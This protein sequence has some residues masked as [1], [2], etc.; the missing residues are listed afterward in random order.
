MVNTSA[1]GGVLQPD[2]APAPL[3]GKAFQVFLQN[4]I[5][6]LC[7]LPGNMVRPRWQPEPDNIPK[8]GDAWVAFGVVPDRSA[9]TFP[10]VEEL[11]DGL[12]TRLQR[13]E[14]LPILCSFYD[15]GS[16]GLA[17]G[18][19][20]LLRDNLAI[21]QNW[22]PLLA[23]GF[24]LAHVGSMQP[25]PVLKSERWLY[26][27]DLSFVLRRQIDRNYN[28]RSLVSAHG[29][30]HTDAGIPPLEFPISVRPPS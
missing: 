25:S 7:D 12:T 20:S 2:A 9:D 24:M 22:E 11:N 6:P 10:Y 4:W 13:Q 1:S 30:I 16:T 29:T 3:E 17:D 5:A 28:V 8:S 15:L 27:M 23:G 26:R 21:P 18:N 19:A 14:E